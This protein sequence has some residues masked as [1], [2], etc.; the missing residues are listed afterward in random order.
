MN[1][2]IDHNKETD[3]AERKS[4]YDYSYSMRAIRI[5]TKRENSAENI[6]CAFH[7]ESGA[8]THDVAVVIVIFSICTKVT[9]IYV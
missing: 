7:S 6:I 1:T 4:R 2:I 3:T 8:H 9:Y 5:I